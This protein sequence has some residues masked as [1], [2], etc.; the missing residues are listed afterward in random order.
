MCGNIALFFWCVGMLVLG[1]I[2]GIL[3]S[4][5]RIAIKDYQKFIDEMDH[6]RSVSDYS[7]ANKGG[8]DE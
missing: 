4:V 2:G 7:K 6:N 5:H 3:Y 8:G 1:F